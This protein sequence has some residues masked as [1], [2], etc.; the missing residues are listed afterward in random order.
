[1]GVSGIA[2]QPDQTSRKRPR[3]LSEP[4]NPAFNVSPNALA[5][6]GLT[7]AQ[8]QQPSQS[9]VL[10]QSQGAP[11][12]PP[13]LPVALGSSPSPPGN[14]TANLTSSYSPPS[15]QLSPLPQLN[16]L[17]MDMQVQFQQ[18]PHQE[19]AQQQ[20]HT[21][22]MSTANLYQATSSTLPALQLSSG[23][24]QQLQM[25][26]QNPSLLPQFAQYLQEQLI[27]TPQ[28]HT[29]PNQNQNS[30]SP[31]GS[32]QFTKPSSFIPQPS[33]QNLQPQGNRS[34][35]ALKA[36]QLPPPTSND[37]ANSAMHAESLQL[38]NHN[39]KFSLFSEQL[40]LLRQQ[41]HVAASRNQVT[42]ADANPLPLGI[43]PST[44]SLDKSGTS[45]PQLNR[46]N[47]EFA[48]Q[49][50]ATTSSNLKVF[51]SCL[52]NLRQTQQQILGMQLPIESPQLE[53]L[54]QQHRQLFSAMDKQHITLVHLFD[55]CILSP[56][57]LYSY[58]KILL[59]TQKHMKQ[60]ELF[61]N[62]LSHYIS[63]DSSFCPAVLF[64]TEQPFPRTIVKGQLVPIDAQLLLASRA[65]IRSIG[66]VS[67]IIVQSQSSKKPGKGI[68]TS[69]SL[70]CNPEQIDNEGKV[71]VNVK[72][73]VGTNKKPV[74]LKLHVNIKHTPLRSQK[75]PFAQPELRAIESNHSRPFI[76]TTNSI[77]WRDSEGMLLRT[78]TFGEMI[79]VSWERFANTF[80]SYYLAATRQHLEFPTRALTTK[81][82]DYLAAIKF[83]NNRLVSASQFDRFW[84]WFG[85]AVEKLRHQRGLCPMWQAGLVYG[86]M[87]KRECETALTGCEDGVSVVRFSDTY[88]GRFALAYVFKGEVHH[89]LMKDSDVA[90]NKRS[91]VD[92]LHDVP[93]IRTILQMKSDFTGN[94]TSS[95]V[96]KEEV[97][98]EFFTEKPDPHTPG[99]EDFPSLE[100]LLEASSSSPPQPQPHTSPEL[101]PGTSSLSPVDR[102]ASS[103]TST[104]TSTAATTSTST[105]NTNSTTAAANSNSN[106]SNAT[107][108][109]SSP[110]SPSPL[111]MNYNPYAPFP[112]QN[113]V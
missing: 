9:Q 6:L 51:S 26:L 56:T 7:A 106:N 62:E 97:M 5:A 111:S 66:S 39:T 71:R 94:I 68:T 72:F 36:D 85:P 113:D 49:I 22:P 31:P 58:K 32:S 10:S 53:N 93:N 57:D 84:E 14:P 86:F 16:Q 59:Q 42:P 98:R 13:P 47:K 55:E 2:E 67:A 30:P 69:V 4:S 92:A 95:K 102:S 24:I 74:T 12:P 25:Q 29:V 107:S 65:D 50:L 103:S 17:L 104:S 33:N 87:S 110:L 41:Q 79:D 35:P 34:E 27:A 61:Q 11:Q 48:S 64:L 88:P 96:S 89:S 19:Q 1:M 45:T 3:R 76:I 18:Q 101:S 80:Q 38:L 108:P 82:L 52:E 105:G 8:L 83:D 21:D 78:D 54:S 60:L 75:T 44:Y 100:Y 112:N 90:G 28:H 43:F 15:Q 63:S 77:Q 70:E 46:Y 37:I 109:N 23:Q 40:Q 81:D 91:L 99:Y 73:M 20:Q